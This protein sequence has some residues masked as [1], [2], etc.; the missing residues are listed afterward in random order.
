MCIEFGREICGILDSAESREWLVT[1]GIGGYASGTIAGLLTRRYHGLLMAA[2]KPP[3]GRTLL[4]AKVDENALYGDKIY[5]LCTNRWTDGIVSPNGYQHIERFSLEGTIPVWRFACADALL[6]KRIWM[7]QGANTTYVHYFLRRASQPLQLTLKAMVNYR[8]YHGSTQSNGWKMSVELV[9][10]GICVTAYESAVPLYLL[11]DRASAVPAHNWYYGFDL[12]AERYRGLSDRE[13]HLHAATFQIIINP[14]ESLTF[15]ASTEKE[16]NLNGETALKLRRTQEQKLITL[17]KSSRSSHAK[18]TPAW[19]NHLVL[20]ADQFIVD[21]PRHDDIHGKTIIAGYHWFSDWGRDTMISLPGVT[22]STGRPEIARSILRT[23]AKYVDKGMLPNRFPDAGETPEYNTVDATLWY[24]EALHAYYR[25]TEDDDLLEELFPILVDIIDWH[26]RGTR[27]NI[28]LDA[29]DGLL[30]AGEAGTQLTWMD[31]KI[32]DWVVT[33]RIGKPIEVNALWYNALQIMANLARH[34]GKPHQ[35]YD[36]MAERTLVRFSRFWNQ[37]AG[38]CYDVL[39][40][41]DG[42]DPSLRP[43]QIFAVSLSES[44]LTPNQQKAVVDACARMLLTSHGLRSLSPDHP[45]Y[46]GQYGG[47]QHQRDTAYHQGTTWGWLIGPFVLAYLRVYKNP[48]QAR[49]FLEP[50]ANH[51]HAHGIGSLSEIFDGDAPIKPRGCIAQA[52]T[53]AEVLRA[54]LVTEQLIAPL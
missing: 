31:A 23:Y 14:G 51:L 44:P 5:P 33:P 26:S 37:E 53:V 4:L 24:F 34:I 35:E 32:G 30:Y 11:S 20:A 47:D 52:W 29:A 42:N 18:E 46:Q 10:R 45:Q 1:N 38:Y 40:G 28:H 3:L 27:Y 41:P 22:L 12:V 25:F 16:P 6:E 36:A 9:E 49:Q 19:V 21:R 50:M 13:D 48:A 7:Q 43:N 8:D 15:V 39:D 54:W 17:W 2:L